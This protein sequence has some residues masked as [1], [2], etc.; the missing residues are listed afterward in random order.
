VTIAAALALGLVLSR[1]TE[2]A[3][4]PS[5][6]QPSAQ[7]SPSPSPNFRTAERALSAEEERLLTYIPND[8]A[9]TCGPF[10][11]GSGAAVGGLVCTS[12]EVEVLYRLFPD[13]GA[14][15]AALQVNANIRGAT[16]GECATDRVALTPYTIDGLPAGRVLCY[17]STVGFFSTE[18]ARSDIEW[19]DERLLV[20]AHA[21][22]N[23]AADLSLYEWWLGSAGPEIPAGDP[24]A[25]KDRPAQAGAPLPEG[26]YL[27]SLTDRDVERSGLASISGIK[28]VIGGTRDWAGTWTLRVGNEEYEL[29]HDGEPVENGSIVTQKPAT[30]LF[31]PNGGDCFAFGR[32]TDPVAYGWTQSGSTITWELGGEGGCAGPQPLTGRPWLRA[33]NG[34]IAMASSGGNLFTVDAAGLDRRQ[35][36]VSDLPP[37]SFDNQPVWSPDGSSIAI[38]SETEAGYDIYVMNPDGTGLRQVTDIEGIELDPAWSPDG[39]KI[40]FHHD[41]GGFDFTHS[42]VYVVNAD[43]SGLRTLVDRQ[44]YVGRPAWSPDG[45]KIALN[46]DGLIYG[47]DADGSNLTLLHGAGEETNGIVWTREGNRIVFADEGPQGLTLFSMRPEGTDVRPMFD[48]LPPG[49]RFPVSALSADGRWIV[50]AD[51]WGVPFDA[52]L[53]TNEVYLM[54]ADGSRVFTI[55]VDSFEPSWRLGPS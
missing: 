43:G 2:S 24:K 52:P 4:G 54:S 35:I 16:G 37:S 10:D 19:T 14:M 49:V 29:A 20:Y 12:E 32:S 23:D 31:A 33:P 44:G 17:R 15:D 13:R 25:V 21:I 55:L 30:F 42:S 9:E 22:R 7:P 28:G 46:I 36:T 6:A 38:A 50:V 26:S 18:G 34:Q 3:G 51:D 41:P 45:T 27:L 47:V 40:A 53:G 5:A 48:R 1:D 11:A 39:S 8:V